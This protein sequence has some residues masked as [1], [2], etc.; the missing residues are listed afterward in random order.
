MTAARFLVPGQPDTRL[1]TRSLVNLQDYGG[2]ASWQ[3]HHVDPDTRF[4]KIQLRGPGPGG[5][6]GSGSFI[7]GGGG[8]SAGFELKLLWRNILPPPSLYFDVLT[9]LGAGPGFLANQGIIRFAKEF[10]ESPDPINDPNG[11]P[12][13]DFW[14]IAGSGQPGTNATASAHGKGGQ[15]GNVASNTPDQDPN[16]AGANTPGYRARWPRSDRRGQWNLS[17]IPGFDGN[18]GKEPGHGGGKG[19]NGWGGD[20]GRPGNAAL[21]GGNGYCSVEEW[22]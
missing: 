9:H 12:L 11:R 20:G 17:A 10:C 6:T 13:D 3:R 5:G 16:G 18:H 15:G 2:S 4:L 8:Q 14:M 19:D 21:S 7:G 22:A 1:I